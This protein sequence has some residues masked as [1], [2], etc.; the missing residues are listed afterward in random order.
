VGNASAASARVVAT[1]MLPMNAPLTIYRDGV[2]SNAYPSL[3]DWNYSHDIGF[4]VLGPWV[5]RTRSQ[6]LRTRSSQRRRPEGALS[7]AVRA[8]PGSGVSTPRH[9]HG[10]QEF[11]VVMAGMVTPP[12]R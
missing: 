10:G 8:R 7:G 11:S 3:A 9:M 6:G 1:A 12:T 2:T 4:G 5:R